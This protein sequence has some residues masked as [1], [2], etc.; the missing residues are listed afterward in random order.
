MKDIS[1]HSRPYCMWSGVLVSVGTG[2]AAAS[3][4]SHFHIVLLLVASGP[5]NPRANRQLLFYDR[6]RMRALLLVN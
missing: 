4:V 1:E 3:T 5:D 6:V 2:A